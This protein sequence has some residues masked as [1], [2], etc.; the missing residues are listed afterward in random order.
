MAKILKGNFGE[1]SWTPVPGLEKL[2]VNLKTGEVRNEETGKTLTPYHNAG[3]YL[4]VSTRVN[5]KR[6][7]PYVQQLVFCAKVGLD[8]WQ[9]RDSGKHVDHLNG[10]THDNRA[11]NLQLVTPAENQR[12]KKERLDAAKNAQQSFYFPEQV[13]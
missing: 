12:R 6:V 5:G 11:V 8:Y 10:D 7:Q 2:S 3:S 4:K 1:K 9:L 13:A